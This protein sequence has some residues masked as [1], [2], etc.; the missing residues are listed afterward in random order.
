LPSAAEHGRIA[1]ERAL[2]RLGAKKTESKALTMVLDNRAA[3]RLVGALA[4]PL[5]GQALQQKRSFFEGKLGQPIGSKLL[6]LTDD[7][8][9]RKGF[10][11]RLFDGEGL[12]ARQRVV[13]EDGV[14]HTYFIDTYYGKKLG[15]APTTGGMSNLSWRLGE[16]SKEQ[17]IKDAGEAI[18]VTGF[19]GGNSNATTGD[20]SLGV[21]GFMIRGGTVAEPVAEMNIAGNQLELWKQLVA[22]GNDPYPF[23][24]LRT[25]TL[26]FDGVSFAGL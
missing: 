10:G 15:L 19:I 2:S 20:Y 22:V 24:T 3:G 12:A 21:Q 8:F 25:P 4:G 23:S 18:Y 26:V 1:A 5:S 13:F 17:L 6:H 7:P 16:R 9:V 11:S 14:L